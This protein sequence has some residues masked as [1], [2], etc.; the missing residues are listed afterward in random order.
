MTCSSQSSTHHAKVLTD[1]GDTTLDHV[2]SLTPTLMP[3]SLN[4]FTLHQ[5][6]LIVSDRVLLRLDTIR[7]CVRIISL[8]AFLTS[9]LLRAGSAR[10]IHRFLHK[11]YRTNIFNAL[12][13]MSQHAAKSC[14]NKSNLL[15]DI[16]ELLYKIDV[17]ALKKRSGSLLT[18]CPHSHISICRY[19]IW[20]PNTSLIYNNLIL[21]YCISAA[22][23]C[24]YYACV[25]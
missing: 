20:R 2:S 16:N 19:K 24:V 14:Y 3:P 9:V 18:S 15:N 1:I 25:R 17:R 5:L 7:W 22:E 21:T 10:Y 12:N 6:V 4:L 13:S 8:L 11:I 23:M